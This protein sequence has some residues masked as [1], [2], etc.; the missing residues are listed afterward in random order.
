MNILPP[1]CPP[2]PRYTEALLLT[3]ANPRVA[4]TATIVGQ[5]AH[6]L[7]QPLSAM[8]AITYYLH[9]TVVKDPNARQQIDKLR[10]LIEQAGWILSDAVHY[11]QSAPARLALHDVHE[12]LEVVLSRFSTEDQDVVFVD[13]ADSF[14][15]V[16][17]DLAQM[18]HLL[19]TALRFCLRTA[20]QA[21]PVEV[22]TY[23]AADRAIIVFSTEAPGLDV[24]SCDGLF[25]PF[26]DHPAPAAG[27]GLAS[28]RRIAEVHGGSCDLSVDAAGELRRRVAR[29]IQNV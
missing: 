17:L 12:I 6:E 21:Y 26:E 28:V 2:A 19:T 18:Q 10:Q 24:N 29:P 23:V 25:S 7:R 5:L 1:D 16:S 11:L 27:L 15:L 8:E 9:L 14:P 20:R 3:E 22:S 4:D 13:L